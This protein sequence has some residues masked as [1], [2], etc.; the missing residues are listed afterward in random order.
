VTRQLE[1]KLTKFS[2]NSPK[3]RQVKKGQNIYNKKAQFENPKRLQ[4]TTFKTL[5]VATTNHVF[6]LHI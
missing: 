1:K 4:Q 3:S 5:K 2:K 6:K